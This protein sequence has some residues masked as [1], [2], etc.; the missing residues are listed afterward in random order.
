MLVDELLPLARGIGGAEYLGQAL[1]VEAEI[2]AA[3]G[4]RAAAEQAVREAVELAFSTPA[5]E[6]WVRF[7]PHAGRHLPAEE[8]RRLLERAQRTP[9]SKIEAAR[10]A[11]AA[12]VI[13]GDEGLAHEAAELYWELEM[14]YEEARCRLDAGEVARAQELAARFGF[15]LREKPRARTGVSG[16]G[17]ADDRGG[18]ASN[19]T[20]GTAGRGATGSRSTGC[21]ERSACW[22][23]SCACAR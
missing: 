3:R 10:L 6:Q 15:E 23:T 9:S 21:P 20:T 2:E 19:E 17:I 14:P 4:N 16:A 12:A 7:L 1:V 5:R 8:V 13:D 18:G 22:A 11:E